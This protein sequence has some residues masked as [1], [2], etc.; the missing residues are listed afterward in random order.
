MVLN[1]KKN[2]YLINFDNKNK[3]ISC[4]YI[5]HKMIICSNFMRSIFLCKFNY[6]AF[7]LK[8]IHKRNVLNVPFRLLLELLVI[9]PL[10]LY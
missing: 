2:D 1:Y 8:T 5:N 4:F 7:T 10:K 6:R 9:S 3:E